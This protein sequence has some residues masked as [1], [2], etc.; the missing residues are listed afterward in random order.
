MN[1]L[2]NRDGHHMGPFTHDQACHMLAE[3]KLQA[4]DLCWQNGSRDWITLDKIPGVSEKTDALRQQRRA[5]AIA[6]AKAAAEG[7]PAQ[8]NPQFV[9]TPGSVNT[10]TYD[11]GPVPQSP[12]NWMRIGVWIGVVVT[13]ISASQ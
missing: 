4:W 5:E 3:G 10:H 6:A 9:A 11:P 8:P 1:I 12:R 2:I 7:G 13:L